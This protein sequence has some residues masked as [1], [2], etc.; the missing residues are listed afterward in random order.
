MIFQLYLTST[1]LRYLKTISGDESIFCY[2]YLILCLGVQV[3]ADKN[4]PWMGTK[5]VI[6]VLS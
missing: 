2:E 3:L 6:F 4:S 1:S 5:I